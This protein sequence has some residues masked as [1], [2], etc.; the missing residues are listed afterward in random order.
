MLSCS[1]HGEASYCRLSG[2]C[3]Q[4]VHVPVLSSAPLQVANTQELRGAA[5]S[6][7]EGKALVLAPIIL[8]GDGFQVLWE[9]VGCSLLSFP[10]WFVKSPRPWCVGSWAT[11]SSLTQL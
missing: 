7:R 5:M 4:L 3:S 1:S 11:T 9:D 8:L 10:L 6:R 2:V